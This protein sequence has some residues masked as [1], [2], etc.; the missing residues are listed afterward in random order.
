MQE[1][2]AEAGPGGGTAHTFYIWMW[3]DALDIRA[4]EIVEWLRKSSL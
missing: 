1:V 2:S 4:T 3:Y